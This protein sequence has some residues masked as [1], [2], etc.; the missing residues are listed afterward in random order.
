MLNKTNKQTHKVRWVNKRY[1]EDRNIYMNILYSIFC[2]YN[3]LYI[4]MLYIIHIIHKFNIKY[5][6]IIWNKY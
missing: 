2:M 1:D 4:Y 3:L 6:C 5:V